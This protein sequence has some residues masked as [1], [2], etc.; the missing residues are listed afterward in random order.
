MN[1][2]GFPPPVIGAGMLPEAASSDE[3]VWFPLTI[4][5][6]GMWFA[7]RLGPAHGVFN[8]AELIEIFGDVD[9]TA[10]YAALNHVAME[11]A[12][13]RLRFA[14]IGGEP[15]QSINPEVGGIFPFV[16]LSGEADPAAQARAWMNEEFLLPHDPLRDRLWA[17]GLIKVG[18]THFY[19]YHRS[20][21]ILIDGF[22]GGLIARRIAEVYGA[23]AVGETPALVPF[24]SLNDL[25]AED[26]AYRQSDRFAAERQYWTSHFADKPA[27]VS[28][29]DYRPSRE[30]GLLR[31]STVLAPEFVDLLRAA[32]GAAQGSFPQLMIAAIAIYFYRMTGA[33]DLVLG[34]PV[35]ARANGRLRRI[36]CMLANAVPLRLKMKPG[37]SVAELVRQVGKRVRE[38][39]RHQRYRYEDLR[40]DLNLLGEGR[41]LFTSVVNIEPF[42]YDLRFGEAPTTVHNLSNGSIEDLAFFVYDRGAGRPVHIDIDANPAIYSPATLERHIARM[43]LLLR[44]MAADVSQPIARLDLLE[45]GERAALLAAGCRPRPEPAM[46]FMPDEFERQAAAT[47]W[48]VAATFE[49]R[50]ITYRA[51]DA[52]ANRIAH[53]LIAAGAGP[54]TIIGV[55]LPRS[56]TMLAALIGVM[57][58][59]AAYLPL[60]PELPAA[61]LRMMVEDA[62]PLLVLTEKTMGDGIFGRLAV[63]LDDKVLLAFERGR[64]EVAS[65]PDSLAYVIYTSGSTGRP[66][67]VMLTRRSFANFL[68]AMAEQIPLDAADRFFAVTTISFDIAALELFLPLIFGARVTIAPKALLTHPPALARQIAA[69]GATIMQSTPSLWDT[70]M[71]AEAEALRG[72]RLLTG[73]EALS[74]ALAS[75]MRGV[76]AEVINLYG[77]TETTVWS[78]MHRVT[79][80]GLP[81]AGSPIARTEI[82]VLD[83]GLMPVPENVAGDL[84]IAGEGLARGYLG[85]RA[86]TAERFVASP[87]GPP[88][89]RMYRTGDLAKF[90]GGVLHYIGRADTQVKLRGFRIELGEIEAALAAQPGVTQAAA[91]VHEGR[92]VA[93]IVPSAPDVPV[94]AN[95]LKFALGQ[96]LPEY[97]VPVIF[98]PMA[99][100]PLSPSGKLDRKAL[101]APVVSGGGDTVARTPQEDVLVSLFCE[102]L[103]ADDIDPQA[104]IFELGA[105]SLTVARIVAKIREVFGVDLP[106]TAM[107]ETTTIAGLAHLIARANGQQQPM[108]RRARPGRIPLGISQRA[109]FEA[110]RAPGAGP[111]FNMNIGLRLRGALD[112][113]AVREAA[114]DL[115]ER[116]ESLRTL[117]DVSEAEPAQRILPPGEASL[118]VEA[119]ALEC[120]ALQDA[121]T[122]AANVTFDATSQLP[123]RLKLWSMGKEDHAL[124]IAVSHVAADGASVPALARDLAQAYAARRAGHPP[125]WGRLAL[126]YADYALWQ[127]ENQTPDRPG[128]AAWKQAL[129]GM[130]HEICLP[131]DAPYPAR[132]G[133]AGGMAPVFLPADLHAA[134]QKL[135]RAHGAS[136]FMV[137]QA[138][139]AV[140][141]FR[142]GAGTDFAIASPVANRSDAALDGMIGCFF[143]RLVLRTDVSGNPS[144]AALIGRVRAFNLFAYANQDAPFDHV[145][146]AVGATGGGARGKLF[147]VMLNFQNLA[148]LSFDMPGLV[149]TPVPVLTN[150]SRHDLTMMLNERRGEDGQPCGIF[151]GLEYRTDVFSAATAATLAKQFGVLLRAAAANPNLRASDLPLEA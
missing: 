72:M 26:H 76:A 88:G 130:P 67:G 63:P 34:L 16:D 28:L 119:E 32:A 141:L 27:P 25:V 109:M 97:M 107:F 1:E 18:E 136:L 51:L 29:G 106:L 48:A 5:Q 146:A 77:P 103:N 61:R 56:E 23:M 39:L 79:A 139:L 55:A 17:T 58:A 69:S 50:H 11:A 134:L 143:N 128:V 43:A 47:P 104:N 100:M 137:L 148:H 123:V 133:F 95:L 89:S 12:A 118:A 125:A 87:F 40:R 49:S 135:A 44:Q 121:I 31:R 8:L 52:M 116:H 140:L 19:W 110:A 120:S 14:E 83:G 142:R 38:A 149:V 3:D 127:Q 93:Y 66:K 86:L 35:T 53:R 96:R 114:A 90:S 68:G 22:A 60:D 33:E 84:Y 45:P 81:P 112:V 117:I 57:K 10:F 102:V 62:R 30:G 151:G 21:H 46:R 115:L 145:A 126:Q 42:D 71:G 92:L 73:G 4:A 129:A 111:A 101:P 122:E 94:D 138:A 105:D 41:H 6:R 99:A 59:G 150:T 7:Q 78:T 82:F 91:T 80:N 74:E 113:A 64:P 124:L 2:A 37:E 36:P 108:I 144:F 70:L 132:R 20:H 98:V 9:V 24:G 13:T 131:T 65:P 147:Q 75:Q 54:E 85:R 15:L